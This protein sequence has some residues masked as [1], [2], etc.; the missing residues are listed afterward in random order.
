MMVLMMVDDLV[1][2]LDVMLAVLSVKKWVVKMV[3]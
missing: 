2:L 3:D 1:A